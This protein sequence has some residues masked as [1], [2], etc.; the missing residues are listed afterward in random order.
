[1]QVRSTFV[2]VVAWVF[3]VLAGFGVLIGILQNI[4]FF[5]FFPDD[6]FL[7]LSE[8]EQETPGAWMFQY[9]RFFVAGLLAI[10]IGVFVTSI[11]LL[12]R[13]N[14]AR[15]VFIGFMILGVVWNLGG[16]IW[17]WSFMMGMPLQEDLHPEFE[18]QFQ[19]MRNVMVWASAAMAVALSTLFGWIAWKLMRPEIRV[20]F[21]S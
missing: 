12:R 1:M 6:L 3:I 15:L 9:V 17:Q 7:Q 11:N 2:D 10:M 13:R 18:R 14:W 4:I 5:M 8:A 16:L 21:S 19:I 20:E